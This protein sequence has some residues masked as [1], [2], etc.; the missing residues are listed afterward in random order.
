MNTNKFSRLWH[1]L[2]VL[3]LMIIALGCKKDEE[4][5]AKPV[6]SFQFTVD[7]DEDG[8]FLKVTFENFSQNTDTYSWDFGD[9]NTSTDES[10]T[11]TYGEPGDYTVTLTAT[12]TDG[13]TAEK[14]EDLSLT[15]P[16]EALTLL[17]GL[18][19]KEWIVQREGAVLFVGPSQTAYDGSWYTLDSDHGK[20]MCIFDDVYT[21]E[22]SGTFLKN[23]NGT[24]FMDL[25]Q[26]GG[27]NDDL[28]GGEGCAD[29]SADGAFTD[30]V[31]GGD[32]SALANGGSYTFDYNTTT[33]NIT[34]TGAGAYIALPKVA[35]G[36]DVGAQA[37]LPGEITFKV[38][39]LVEGPIADTLD[40]HHN[41]D[42]GDGYWTFK[43]VSY[44]NPS[45]IPVLSS[46]FAGF[47]VTTSGFTAD[48]TNESVGSTSY[49]WDFGDG[50]TGTDENP[51]HTYAAD[52]TYSVSLTATDGTDSNTLTK[53]VIIDT[54]NPTDAAPTPS[55]N[56]ADVISIYSDAYTNIDPVDYNPN[57]SQATVVTEQEVVSGDNIL[58]LA[59]LNYQGIDFDGNR[60]D[61]SGKTMVHVDIWSKNAVTINFSLIWDGA[62]AP[63][64]LTTVAGQWNSFDIPLS[65]FTGVD[66]T[67]IRQMKFDDAGSGTSPTIFVDNVYF[68]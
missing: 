59:G 36:G 15:D 11:Y 2:L 47:S 52:G 34:I 37:N 21:F 40:L 42:G 23:T 39:N 58:K 46:V 7:P 29:E 38:V 44:H 4:P 51:S 5:A 10:P 30:S 54:A 24:F 67:T 68:Y 22:R 1:V 26:N 64:G 63:K 27:W 60:Q 32:Y 3:P 62:E 33:G 31:T 28:L 50:T 14:S 13:T 61:V 16:N 66:L 8:T 56:E 57:W 6:A 48:F 25:R 9:G 12:A 20:R 65:D 55:Q 18:T 49:S 35:N 41:P 19:S 17:A 53:D 45:D 43:L